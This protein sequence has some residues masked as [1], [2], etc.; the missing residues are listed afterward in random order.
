[1][2]YVLGAGVAMVLGLS[3]C[4][5]ED[6]SHLRFMIVHETVPAGRGVSCLRVVDEVIGVV[7]IVWWRRRAC[8]H[9]H[10]EL[11]AEKNTATVAWGLRAAAER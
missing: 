11:A 3:H 7:P 5:R 2:K 8:L 1:M 9:T 6:F 4:Q 10:F